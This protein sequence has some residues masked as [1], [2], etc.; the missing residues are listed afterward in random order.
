MSIVHDVLLSTNYWHLWE[1]N[2]IFN[3]RLLWDIMM[4]LLWYGFSNIKRRMLYRH[5]RRSVAG[6]ILCKE[7]SEDQAVPLFVQLSVRFIEFVLNFPVFKIIYE[8]NL[9]IMYSEHL[10]NPFSSWFTSLNSKW[11]YLKYIFIF[12]WCNNRSRQVYKGYFKI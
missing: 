4:R 8:L 1:T 6:F 5:L 7:F 12:W 9:N 11:K 2:Y 10:M 3:L